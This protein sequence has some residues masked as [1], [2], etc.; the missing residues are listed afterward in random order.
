MEEIKW[1][2]C[3]KCG[4]VL[5][6]VC[7]VSN[8]LVKRI[9]P[10]YTRAVCLQCETTAR[11]EEK[12]KNRPRVKARTTLNRHAKKWVKDGI[13]KNRIDLTE[14]Y[15]WD[16]EQM[17][18]DITHAY[19]GACPS[20]HR[21]FKKLPNGLGEVSLDHYDR[22]QPPFYRHNI[23]WICRTCNQ[24]KGERPPQVYALIQLGWDIWEKHH[25][26]LAEDSWTGTLFEGIDRVIVEQ[27]SLMGMTA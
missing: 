24:A 15:G 11:T 16:V 8:N 26:M 18:H 1:K 7:F 20:C 25:C 19:E 14:I 10:N 23:R 12:I 2:R 21:L 27:L 5:P 6:L 22:A 13:I 17:A 9:S 4:L 3:K